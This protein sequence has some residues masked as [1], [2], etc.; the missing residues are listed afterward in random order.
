MAASSRLAACTGA[1]AG[2]TPATGERWLTRVFRYDVYNA[3]QCERLP[4]LGRARGGTVW[5]HHPPVRRILAVPRIEAPAGRCARYDPG[6]DRI[7]LPGPEAFA[8]RRAYERVAVHEVGHWTGHPERLNRPSLAEGV[9]QG[10]DSRAYAREELRAELHSYLSGGR[11]AIGHDPGPP[12]PFRGRVGRGAARGP[13][14]VLT[15]PP[16]TPSGSPAS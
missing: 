5:S 11:L 13:A 16:G 2:T 8:D 4:E 10:V 12:R 6:R 1:S 14:R 15:A 3:E 7:E 9:A